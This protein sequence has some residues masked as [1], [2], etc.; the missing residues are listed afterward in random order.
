MPAS[1]ASPHGLGEEPHDGVQGMIDRQMTSSRQPVALIANDQEWT[2]RSLESLLEPNGFEVMRAYTGQQAL[3]RALNAL[4]D[5]IILDAQLPDIHGF[6]VCRRL[7]ADDRIGAAVP[8]V[9]TTSGPAGRAQRLQAYQA[10]AWEFF[11]QP[12]DAEALLPRLQNFVQAK[13]AAETLRD[14][15]L[16]DAVSGLYNMR[17]LARRTRELSAQ[18]RRHRES[19]ACVV[20]SPDLRGSADLPPDVVRRVGDELGSALRTHGRIS[21]AIGRISATEFAVVTTRTEAPGV[22][23]MLERLQAQLD[24]S[25]ARDGMPGPLRLRA[26]SCSVPDLADSVLE[27]AEIL[28]RAT[29]ALRESLRTGSDVA[30]LE[31][32][33]ENGAGA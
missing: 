29:S 22:E 5:L 19:L 10:G 27:P 3:D 30:I 7:R 4:P 9:V 6:D 14:Q 2:A 25:A 17:G 20:V 24:Q 23:R 15:G 12:L 26:G 21:D 31:F 11:G 16:V 28:L 32:R 18:A 1:G 8:I 33:N 13:L